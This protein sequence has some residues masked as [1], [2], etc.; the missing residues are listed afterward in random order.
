MKG[1]RIIFSVFLCLAL[2]AEISFAEEQQR[3]NR[4]RWESMKPEERTRVISIYREWKTQ[5]PRQKERIRKNYE[6][7]HEMSPSEQQLLKQRFRTYRQLEPERREIVDKKLRD[8]DSPH[9]R[10]SVVIVRKHGAVREKPDGDRKRGIERS[11]FWKSLNDE[12]R[13]I[14]RQLMYPE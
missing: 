5:D 8:V 14:F 12:E 13:K 4:S 9:S 7:Y 11:H 2:V 10:S 1:E 3:V 6:A